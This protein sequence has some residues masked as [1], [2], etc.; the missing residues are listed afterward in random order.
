MFSTQL[1]PNV[2]FCYIFI[3]AA[4]AASLVSVIVAVICLSVL[5]LLGIKKWRKKGTVLQYFGLKYEILVE[6]L[7]CKIYS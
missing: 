7:Q 4:I 1:V 6:E 2:L 3:T 5:L